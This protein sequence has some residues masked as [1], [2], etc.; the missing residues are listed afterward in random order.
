MINRIQNVY[1]VTDDMNE[2]VAFT[3]SYTHLRA[4]ET[5]ENL[6]WRHQD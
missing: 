3:V 1:Y 4:H 5:H 6:G 2:T